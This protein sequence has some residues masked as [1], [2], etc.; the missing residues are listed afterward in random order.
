MAEPTSR[1]RVIPNNTAESAV[2]NAGLRLAEISGQ[3]V[4]STGSGN[5]MDFGTV[6]ISAGAA[7]SDV[8]TLLW[9]ITADGGNTTAETF[10]MW[11]STIDFTQEAS[12]IKFQPLSGADQESASSTEGYTV[13]AAVGDYT[14]ATMPEADPEAQNL[15]P[16][17]EGTSMAL[18]TASDDEIM[19]AL[20]ASVASGETT[21]TYSGTTSNYG[22]QLSLKYSY[23]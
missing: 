7:N 3:T 16:S 18:S 2:A 21:G 19:L 6:D 9:G 4:V 12:V 13:S 20:Y 11:V 22:L 14:W 10:M 15:Y 17:D 5:E 23:S 1:F 8:V